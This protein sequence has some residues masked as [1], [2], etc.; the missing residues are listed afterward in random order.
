MKCSVKSNEISQ[1]LYATGSTEDA[2][3]CLFSFHYELW[4]NTLVEL[5]NSAKIQKSRIRIITKFIRGESCRDLFNNLKI[6]HLLSQY[7]P[8][9]LLFVV[10]NKTKI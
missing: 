2:L 6:L 1:A 4:I 10:T 3:L 9:L 7:I 8:S 5:F